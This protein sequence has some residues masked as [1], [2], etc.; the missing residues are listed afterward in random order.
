VQQWQLIR[1]VQPIYP[2]LALQA[3]IQ[4][5][6]RLHALIG[7]DGRV[8]KLV[9]TE[10]HPLLVP[11][12]LQAVK[13]WLYRPTLLNGKAVEVVTEIHVNFGLAT[14]PT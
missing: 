10:G 7:K 5:T 11:A 3:R 13:Q 4:G 6:V 8:Q 12:A 2:P 1:Q 9:V 14:R